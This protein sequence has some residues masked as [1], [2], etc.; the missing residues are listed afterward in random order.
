MKRYLARYKL[1]LLGIGLAIVGFAA[2]GVWLNLRATEVSY[3]TQ[4]WQ[5]STPEEQGIDS[6]KLAEGLLA[7]QRNGIPIHSLM[8]VRHGSVLL[9]A[10]FY[11][12]DGTI[13]HDTAS[14]T[15]SLMTTLVGIAVDQGKIDLD[16]QMVFFF[17]ERTIANRDERKESITVRHLVSMTSGLDCGV[18]NE[19][20]SGEMQ[21]SPDWVQFAL[22]RP[23]TR[24]PGARFEYCNLGMHLLSAILR[25]ATGMTAL[26]FARLNLFDP[27]GIHDVYWPAD[28]QGNNHGWGDVALYPKDM[29]RIGYLFLRQGAWEGKQVIS[30]EWISQATTPQAATGSYKPEDYGF[31]WWVSRTGA[32]PEFYAADGRGGQRILMIPGWDMLLVTTGGGFDFPQIEGYLVPA[33]K[34]LENPLPANPDGARQLETALAEIGKS[35]VAQSVPPTPVTAA[36]VSG[37]TFQL[38]ENPLRIRS[39]R[40]DFESQDAAVFVLKLAYEPEARVI[41][42]GLD[43]LYRTS[44]VGRPI[45][46][47]G[48]WQEDG[49]FSIDYN[50]GP[51][52][53]VYTMRFRFVEDRLYFEMDHPALDGKA[54][55]GIPEG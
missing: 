28:P 20:T 29:A 9:D 33:I 46:A 12:Y 44:T 45:L 50:E 10:T 1:Y 23:M 24:K 2:L 48:G 54:I 37:K 13:Y 40:L 17:P 7:M 47:R 38:E 36:A 39:V 14:V 53:A 41:G 26:E 43:G 3:P 15:K 31:G 11:P 25:E 16:R 21:L 34:D 35:P 19:T 18:D 30:K 51:G 42:V 52:L 55:E 32:D 49:T 22:D 4:T 5:T 27:L 8:I 6:A